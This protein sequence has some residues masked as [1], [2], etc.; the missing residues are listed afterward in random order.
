MSRKKFDYIVLSVALLVS[1]ILLLVLANS[2]WLT[3]QES[4][5]SLDVSDMQ[6]ERKWDQTEPAQT[7]RFGP[8]IWISSEELAYLPIDGLAWENLLQ[9]A[10]IDVV[11]PD[12]SDQDD[13]SDVYTLAKAL[14]YART[15]ET[16]YR[17]DV[18]NIILSVMGTE[19]GGRTLAL[20][21]N[22]VGYVVAADLINLAADEDVDQEFRQWL[23]QLLSKELQGRTL[24]STHEDRPNNWG[25]HA[26]ASR[27]AIAL[28]LRDR[29]EL[30]ETAQVFHGYLGN[31]NAYAGF[32][33]GNLSWQADPDAPVGIN[34]MGA[35]KQGYLIDGSLP[36][37]MRRGGSFQWMPVRTGYVWEG[38]Q[39]AIVQANLLSRAGYPV[40]EWEDKALLRAI[41][42][43]YRLEWPANGDD[44]WQIW[45]INDVYG[46]AYPTALP[47]RPG[48]NMGWTDWTHGASS[49]GE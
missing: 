43:L 15:G 28:Y 13:D 32:S 46:T 23:A 17:Q 7:S 25:T 34:P 45:L 2:E 31:R 3:L 10:H 14:V 5:D 1:L 42:F 12:L 49:I 37:E 4:A 16:V 30:E 39:G 47:A 27:A 44:E 11:A 18:V 20:G 41:E 35:M 6:P 48:K 21:R 19:E 9:A 26:G 8:G 24:R 29:N 36:E 40:W 22:L 33:Y 38:L